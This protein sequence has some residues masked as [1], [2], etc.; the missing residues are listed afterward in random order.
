MEEETVQHRNYNEFL[1]GYSLP[2]AD[3]LD[4]MERE[5][6]EVP[7]EVK[8]DNRRLWLAGLASLTAGAGIFAASNF[9]L[10]TPALPW[11]IGAGVAGL[12]LGIMRLMGKV[13]RKKTLSLPMVELRRKTE[14]A[15]VTQDAMNE[16]SVSG[17]RGRLTKSETDKVFMGVSGGLAAHSGISSTLIRI[18][19]IIAFGV[20]SGMAGLLYVAMGLFMPSAPKPLPPRRG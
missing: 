15:P 19:W 3:D 8:R 9:G 18:A 1:S 11:F 14:K 20:T 2:S 6:N 10:L 12:G 13:F 16:F 17:R 7:E 4:L 5:D